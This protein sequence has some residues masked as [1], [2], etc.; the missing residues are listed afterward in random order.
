MFRTLNRKFI[1]GTIARVT[2]TFIVPIFHERNKNDEIL[3]TDSD[4]EAQ[5]TGWDRLRAMYRRNLLVTSISVYRNRSSLSD[6]IV[7]GSLTGA[8]YKAN[9]GPTA[10]LVGAGVGGVLSALGGILILGL[11]KITG[12]SMDDI[13]KS[14]YKI[15]ETRQQLMDEA[16]EKSAK[17][18]ND[19]L[20][21]HHDIIVKEKGV[22]KVEDL[23]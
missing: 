2:P 18:K 22:Q 16:I 5:Q 10:M 4:Y 3:L 21:M 13:R 23:P 15:K 6:Y 8:I 11:L 7:G 1:F 14:L 12:L 17:E 20:T 19:Q 9:L